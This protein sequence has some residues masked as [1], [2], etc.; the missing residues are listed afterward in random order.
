MEYVTIEASHVPINARLVRRSERELAVLL[1]GLNYSIDSPLLYYT[2]QLLHERGID[3]VSV[4]FTYN[5][6]EEFLNDTDDNRLER[7]KADGQSIID[8]SMNLGKYDRLTIVGKSL[9][10][11]SMGWAVP[12]NPPNTRLVWL[13]PSLGGTGL[14]AQMSS[15]TNPAFCLIGTHDPAYTDALVD[16]ISTPTM[17]VTVIEGADH[18]FNHDNGAEASVALVQ[19][20]VKKL[21]VWLDATD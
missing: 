1:P 18:V 6:D 16:E 20:A 14:R 15:Y 12:D 2:S 21:A 3:T 4:D 9:G 10:T 11:I 17:T 8:F 19:Q 7:L 13:T 5:R